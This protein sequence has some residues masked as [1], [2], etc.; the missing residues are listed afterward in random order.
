MD[1]FAPLARRADETPEDWG[2]RLV[3]DL[4]ARHERAEGIRVEN[5]VR[6]VTGLEGETEVVLDLV[7]GEWTLRRRAGEEVELNEYTQRFPGM[8]HELR[9]LW[10]VDHETPAPFIEPYS[11]GDLSPGFPAWYGG[12]ASLPAAFGEF[13]LLKEFG[14]GGMARVF[15]AESTKGGRLVALKVPKLPLEQDAR[16]ARDRGLR[17]KRFVREANVMQRLNHPRLCRALEVG[18][19]DGLPFFT[20]PYYPRGSVLEELRASGAFAQNNAV[21]LVAEVARAMQHAHELGILHRDLKPSNLLRDD[22]GHIVVSDFGLA[23]MPDGDQSRLTSYGVAPGTPLYLSPEQVAG[24]RKLG[25]ASDIYSLGVIFYELLTGR[26]PFDWSNLNVLLRSINEAE[27]WP[28]KVLRPEVP[29]AITAICHKA[30][31]KKPEDRQRSMQEL[32]DEL[33]RCSSGGWTPSQETTVSTVKPKPEVVTGGR[34]RR[35]WVLAGSGC[36]VWIVAGSCCGVLA[37]AGYFAL[38]GVLGGRGVSPGHEMVIGLTGRTTTS[39]SVSPT[40]ERAGAVASQAGRALASKREPIGQRGLMQRMRDDLKQVA[41]SDRPH[42]RYFSLLAVH[43][44]PY[45][46]DPDYALHFDALKLMLSRLSGG[47]T[48]GKA[49][50]VDQSGCLIRVDLRDLGWDG[51]D[52]KWGGVLSAEPY[53]VRYDTAVTADGEL[54]KLAK[55]VDGLAQAGFDA[56][57]VRGDWFIEA[58][59][60]CAAFRAFNEDG[61]RG[62]EGAGAGPE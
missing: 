1:D 43:D 34:S 59:A 37:L 41:P 2:L 57:I 50:P 4:T 15:L 13:R 56:P 12:A 10:E 25:P 48:D 19:C 38:W 52:D 22:E 49:Y 62:W 58:L 40:H 5:L 17:Q 46:S 21:R 45:M 30:L 61:W 39:D 42:V 54:R 9:M 18:E 31:A 16:S 55:E 33:D 14:G 36:G 29:G 20:M 44:N 6:G 7:V 11:T 32:A 8:E 23:I 53:G 51:A 26:P 28:L 47:K 60:Q 24:E 35:G 3:G 27:P